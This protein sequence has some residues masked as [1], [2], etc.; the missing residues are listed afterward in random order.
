MRSGL[1]DFGIAVRAV[2][3]R[4]A[5]RRTDLAL[6]EVSSGGIDEAVTRRQA[7]LDGGF[8]LFI[9]DLEDTKA[10][11]R[12]YDAIVQGERGVASRP[13]NLSDAPHGQYGDGPDDGK[14]PGGSV[15]HAVVAAA[16][17]QDDRSARRREGEG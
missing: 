9:G 3:A 14:D 10:E 16:D 2:D 7:A 15:K 17:R 4:A 12:H 1:V 6:I 13:C 5:N 11:A 8:R